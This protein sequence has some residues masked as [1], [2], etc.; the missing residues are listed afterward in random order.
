MKKLLLI[1]SASLSALSS[2]DIRL[3]APKSGETVEQLWPDIKAF[4]DMPR[5]ERQKNAKGLSKKAQ[6]TFKAHRGAKPVKFSWTGAKDGVYALKVVRKSDGRVFHSSTV[7]GLSASVTGRLEVGREWT[8][9]VS[10]GKSTASGHFFTEDRAPRIMKF[11]GVSNARDFGGWRTKDGR[12]VRQGLA[13]RTGGLNNNAKNTY[14]TYEEIVELF[15]AGKLAGAGVGK[16]A[17][18]LSRSY[19]DKLGRG[20]G[21]D[22]GFLRLIKTP[23]QGPGTERL[24][25][26]DR[27]YLMNDLK[28]KSDL[29]LRGDWETF[30][31]LFSPISRDVNWFHYETISGYQG[32]VG[33][34]GRACQTL[35]FSVFAK[36]ENYPIVF[37]C[38]GGTDRTGTLAYLLN[39]LLGVDKEDLIRDYEMSFI[40]NGGV[41]ERHYSW[42]MRMVEA[43][44]ALPGATLPEKIYGYYLSLGF[45]RNDID[46]FRTRMLE[47]V[48]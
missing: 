30:G 35:N 3:V 23:P 24:S 8:W 32:C 5:A 28:V 7:T 13:F 27:D 25:A 2:A 40:S 12:R 45:T 36:D 48:K 14:Y 9:T 18:R 20:N 43:V 41:D 46:G 6:R 39:G 47:D 16:D 15:K 38:I 4:L 44:D 42:L 19:A 29:D 34:V 26:A 33:P 10:D 22:P 17:L 21:I 1:V 11:D 37:H 31:M